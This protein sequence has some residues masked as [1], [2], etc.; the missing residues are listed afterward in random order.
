[1]TGIGMLNS[2]FKLQENGSTV[3]R[4]I[5]AGL[6]TFFTMCYIIIV[7]PSILS[8]AGMQFESVMVATCLVVAAGSILCGL[9]AN[10]PVALAPGLGLLSY[11]AFVVVGQL[12]YSWQAG[13]GTVLLAGL[14][15]FIITITRVR[16]LIIKAIPKSLGYATAAGIGLFIGF[17]ALK[18]VGLVVAN[19]HTLVALGNVHSPQILLCILGFFIIAVLTRLDVPGAMI[20]GMF[21]VSIVGWLTG[22]AKWQGLF[23]MPDFTGQTLM[24][25]DMHHVL[26]MAGI[27][28]I[29]TFLLVALFDSTGSLIA[30][31]LHLPQADEKLKAKKINRALVSESLST[32]LGSVLGVTTT[33]PFIENAAGIKA[34]GRTGLTAIVVAICFLLAVFLGPLA[35]SI[36]EF[37]TSSALFFV[38]C[39]MIRPASY[40]DWDDL[41]ET[42]PA[43]ITLMTIPLTFSIVDG[44]GLGVLAYSILKLSAG[45]WREVHPMLAILAILF[46]AYFSL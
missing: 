5:L 31:S 13:L 41:T 18:N 20:I 6:T 43:T 29:F 17:I 14:I 32:M 8:H 2:L 24:A 23:A 19:A 22:E 28:V 12:G 21:L 36:P 33:A 9:L 37:A 1:M 42:I 46:I 27:P 15:F 3:S 26:S 4:E 40:I 38:A 34:G 45:K 7:A 44:V 35:T 11:F 25:L 16:E 30:L 10:Y 39:I